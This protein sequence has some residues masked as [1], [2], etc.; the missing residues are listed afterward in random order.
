MKTGKTIQELAA[1]I[2]RQANSKHDY[3]A[4][5]EAMSIVADFETAPTGSVPSVSLKLGDKGNFPLNDIAHDQIAEHVKVPKP[6]YDRMRKEAPHL[7]ATNIDHWFRKYPAKRLVRTLDTRARAF[8]SDKFPTDLDNIDFAN[9]LLPVIADRK[10]NVMSC[11]LTEKRLYIKAVD[12]RLYRDVPVGYKMGDGSHKI[13]DTCAPCI[14][15]S[16]S[17]VGFG[18]MVVETGVYTRGCTN[19]CLWANGGMKRTHVGARHQIADGVD[20]DLLTDATKKKTFEAL[21]MQVRDVLGAA[22][23]DK[24]I[25]RRLEQLQATSENKITGKVD[26]VVE[27]AA[28]HFGLNDG[29]RENVLKHLIEGGSLTQ[30]GLHAAVTRSAQDADSYD[31]ATELEYLGGKIIELPKTDWARL[32]E[33]A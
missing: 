24:Q 11:E 8:L 23:E 32:A 12:E 29:E 9:A 6:Y 26:E 20:V 21:W 13:F 18:R 25:T 27:V 14:I 10:L 4:T 22:F 28:K 2:Q 1:E 5:T 15:L 19:L 33:A 3:V 30:Y 17:E 16:N 7:L 31:R